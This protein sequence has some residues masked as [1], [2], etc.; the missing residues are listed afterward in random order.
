MGQHHL[1][2]KPQ[3]DCLLARTGI[4]LEQISNVNKVNENILLS[5]YTGHMFSPFS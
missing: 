4:I 5:E 1:E 3:S 2:K